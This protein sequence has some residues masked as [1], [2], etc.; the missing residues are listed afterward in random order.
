MNAEQRC[1]LDML[2]NNEI[3]IKILVGVTGSGKTKL[4]VEIGLHGVTDGGDFDKLVLVRNPIGSG[5]D[6]GF[7]PGTLEEKVNTFYTP[8]IENIE[9]GAESVDYL[10][11]KCKL[12]KKIPFHMKGLTLPD[13]YVLVDEAED[14]D[15]KTLKLIGSRVGKDS[16]VVFCG[17]Y[18]QA[19]NKFLANNGLTTLIEA[20]KG[21]PLVGIV[22]LD[23]DVR[24]SASRVF[25]GLE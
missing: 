24:S 10:V 18:R 8:I 19:E 16:C 22:V 11:K 3:P 23:Y 20:T 12:D 9:G 1:A 14:L 5:E 2:M 25:A 6:I 15:L 4:A 13:S 17:D 7:L 21:N